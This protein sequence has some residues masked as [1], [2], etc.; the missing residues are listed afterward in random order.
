MPLRTAYV[1]SG[2]ALLVLVTMVVDFNIPSGSLHSVSYVV[3]I[4]LSFWLSWSGAPFALALLSTLLV[5]A[6]HYYAAADAGTE[7][8]WY[9]ILTEAAVLWVAAILVRAFV[10]SVRSLEEREEKS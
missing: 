7:L 9:N 4:S 8:I 3:L 6:Q 5:M 10:R 2:A 1:L